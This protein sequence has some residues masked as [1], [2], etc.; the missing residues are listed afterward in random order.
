MVITTRAEKNLFA[1]MQ[2]VCRVFNR[3]VH[4]VRNHY[5]CHAVAIQFANDFVHI[6]GG[7]IL[8]ALCVAAGEAGV[9]FTLGL[10]LYY[11]IKARKLDKK[12]FF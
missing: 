4:I 1:Q 12:L 10:L 11:T 8:N 7:F 5:Y 9:M 6:G 3:L 2:D